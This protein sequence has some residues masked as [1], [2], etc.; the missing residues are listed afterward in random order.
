MTGYF[1]AVIFDMDGVLA[2]T[3]PYYQEIERSLFRRVGL[4]IRPDEHETFKGVAADRMWQILK[5]KYTLVQDVDELI[6]LTTEEMVP[7]FRRLTVIEPYKGIPELISGLF[8]NGIPLALA[9]SSYPEVIDIV[10]DRTGLTSFFRVVVNSEMAGAS[11]PDPAVFLLAAEKLGI[12]PR[13]C[14][15]VEDSANGIKAA[16]NAGMFCVAVDFPENRSQ[17]KSE[18]NRLVTNYFRFIESLN[19][20]DSFNSGV[21]RLNENDRNNC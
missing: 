11:K 9:S 12:E 13:D 7:F 8:A 19:F 1:K 17:D 3:E 15:V 16:R 21:F 20:S 6:R 5:K 2:N 18:A 10:L 14:M 4:N